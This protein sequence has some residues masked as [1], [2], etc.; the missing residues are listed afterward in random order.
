[1]ITNKK[2]SFLRQKFA[3]L[4]CVLILICE[5]IAVPS[6]VAFE[7][8][9]GG[10][11]FNIRW[12][13][14]IKYSNAYRIKDQSSGLTEGTSLINQDDGD[15]NFDKGFISNRFDLLSELDIAYHQMGVRLSGA[16]WYDSIYES[17]ND[18]DDA[19][20]ANNYSVAYNKFTDETR[21]VHGKDVELLDAFAY[22]NGEIAGKFASIRIGRHAHQWGQ[23]L[24]YGG[25]GIAGAMAPVDIVTAATVPNS[26]FK[27]IIRP[28]NQVSGI[29]EV[30]EVFSIAAYYQ[31]EWEKNRFPAAGSY[32]STS[33]T[34]GEGTERLLAGPYAFYHTDDQDASDNGQGGISFSYSTDTVDY[35][36]YAIQY[37]SKSPKLYMVPGAGSSGAADSIGDYYWVYPEDIRM[38]G[39]SASKTIGEFNF[40]VEAAMSWNMPL[41]SN[42][43]TVYSGMAADNDD[44][45]LYAVGRTA[46]LNFN[47]MATLSPN[48]IANEASFLGEIAAHKLLEIT[49]N[50]KALDPYCSD[51]GLAMRL[52]YTPTYR[53]VFSGVDISV[54]VGI[55]YNPIGNSPIG[56]LGADDGGDMNAG[57]KITYLEKYHFSLTYTHF[58]G[59]EGPFLDADNYYTYQ[60]SQKDRDYLAFS[61][62][63]TF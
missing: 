4:L 22:W 19:S 49:D 62:S 2:K 3:P 43:Q 15:R 24:F 52:V 51:Y 23:S 50:K 29:Y 63:T 48:F 38:L 44:N 35:G 34:F 8:D 42:G 1:M 20:H 16:A 12:D 14:T 59:A 45:P 10:S 60:Q 46:H 25:N 40:A 26:Q 32:L 21:D 13:N 11:D 31:F 18:H 55:S 9:T 5:F 28:V 6:A 37:H 36:V 41:T 33:D 53:Q 61:V 17:S 39:V 47:W 57:L 58:Y 27:E 56:G 30:T 7:I 54:P